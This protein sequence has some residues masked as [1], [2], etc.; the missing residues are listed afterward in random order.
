[1][2]K[3][4]RRLRKLKDGAQKAVNKGKY[5]KA[6]DAYLE[7]EKV[8]PGDG[9]W[10][11]RA[12]DMYRRLRRPAEAIVA[13]ERAA[14]KY[15]RA[16]FLVKAVAVCK[17][18]LQ[19]DPK[20]SATLSRLAELQESRG[21]PSARRVSPPTPAVAAESADDVAAPPAQKATVGIEIELEADA[22]DEMEIVPTGHAAMPR[23]VP[24]AGEVEIG[25][26]GPAGPSAVDE[27]IAR[28]VMEELPAPVTLPPGARAEEGRAGDPASPR[29]RTIPPGAPLDQVVLSEVMPGSSPE[30]LSD[31]SRSG[32][33]EIPLELDLDDIEV[34]MDEAEAA[35]GRPAD[36]AAREAA[37]SLQETPLF[38]ALGPEALQ[39]FINK[40][41]LV[42]L[43]ASQ[44][45]FRQGETGRTLYVVA[46]GEVA[47]VAEGPPRVQLSRLGEGEFFGEIAL[48]TEQPRSATIE[49]LQE[50]QLLAVDRDVIGDLVDE[51]PEVLRVLLRFLRDRLV[52]SLIA[53]SP[54]FGHFEQEHRAA[55]AAQ[56]RFLEAEK[57]AE[58]VH[59]GT[60]ADGLFVMLSGQAE[61][62]L[63]TKD[64]KGRR[65]ATLS[66]G[67]LFGE[68][69]LLA[70][71]PAVATVRSTSK[72]FLFKLPADV[73]RQLIMTHPQVLMFVGDLA[74]ERK[75]KYDAIVNGDADYEEGHLELV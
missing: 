72:C 74:D 43:T 59:Q 30:V 71:A 56:F 32:V 64:G 68:M 55:L 50:T 26:R 19:A 37:L 54:L 47:V 52:N 65:I 67:D 57:D 35:V 18:I 58:F 4:S 27:A 41:E 15:A 66:A 31:G 11:R 51:E 21:I 13:L 70:N 46:E 24:G 49:A 25:G 10:P 53:T 2:A 29:R 69:S 1:M 12:A 6:L 48:V 3:D 16:G 39:S 42:E 62:V 22:A 33:T 20:H 44:T 7:L 9:S 34:L 36:Q 73:F 38:S 28:A 63:T 23:P 61:V 14:D 17:L 45:L 8:E 60:R 75:R 5:D 40:I